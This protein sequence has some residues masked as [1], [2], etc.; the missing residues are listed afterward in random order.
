MHFKKPTLVSP[1]GQNVTCTEFLNLS[2]NPF[3]LHLSSLTG[4]D[5]KIFF[6]EQPQ[7]VSQSTEHYLSVN[8]LSVLGWQGV[9]MTL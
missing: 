5:E 4:S 3:A 9:G 1:H 6:P 8:A 7:A 2:I